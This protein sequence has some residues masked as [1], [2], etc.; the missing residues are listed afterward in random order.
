[1]NF[2]LFNIIWSIKIPLFNNPLLQFFAVILLF[3]S[4]DYSGSKLLYF[5]TSKYKDFEISCALYT[6]FNT[7]ISN[8]IPPIEYIAYL[9]EILGSEEE[10]ELDKLLPWSKEIVSQYEY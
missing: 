7:A 9:I 1:M 6:L 8:A 5:E 3:K 10:I 2:P 4:V